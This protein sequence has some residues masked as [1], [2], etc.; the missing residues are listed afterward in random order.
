[1]LELVQRRRPAA[2]YGRTLADRG[3]HAPDLAGLP[4][5]PRPRLLSAG[6][7][8]AA[9]MGSVYPDLYAAVGVHSGLACG[10]AV[11]MPSAFTAMRQGGVLRS[12]GPQ[13]HGSVP[14][15]APTIVFR[16]DGD[17]IVH[18]T[19]GDQIIA[20]SQGGAE[21]DSEISTGESAGGMPIRASPD[22]SGRAARPRAL[23]AARRPRLVGRKFSRLLYGA[24]PVVRCCAS[25]SGTQTL[26][27][28]HFRGRQSR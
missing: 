19:N 1:M 16:G 25:S 8:T 13:Q 26:P 15:H 10:A 7:A 14:R 24:M 18:P 4:R 21:F 9:I 11:D 17:K 12:N 28:R 23:G 20:Q 22:G 27:R 2:R 5:R 6:G 3:H